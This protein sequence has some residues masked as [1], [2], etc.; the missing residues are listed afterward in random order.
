MSL[1]RVNLHQSSGGGNSPSLENGH[2]G[3]RPSVRKFMAILSAMAVVVAG[4]TVGVAGPAQAAV[5]AST[6][7]TLQAANNQ[8]LVT[9]SGLKATLPSL[10][11]ETFTVT[12]TDKT[13]LEAGVVTRLSATEFVVKFVAGGTGTNNKLFLKDAAFDTIPTVAPTVAVS[14]ISPSS[15]ASDSFNLSGKSTQ[16]E[17]TIPTGVFASDLASGTV[18]NKFTFTP[19]RIITGIVRNSDT[20]ATLTITA[21][22]AAANATLVANALALATAAGKPAVVATPADLLP[23]AVTSSVAAGDNTLTVTLAGTG[24]AFIDAPVISDF[25]F[26][27]G[28]TQ[29]R[30]ALSEGTVIATVPADKNV[31]VIRFV[32]SV[33]N[34]ATAGSYTVLV[35]ASALKVS[36]STATAAATS[37]NGPISNAFAMNANTKTVTVTITGGKFAA[38]LPTTPASSFTIA[39]ASNDALTNSTL[40]RVNDTTVTLTTTRAVVAGV[41]NRLTPLAAALVTIPTATVVS[42][43]ASNLPVIA[44]VSLDITTN[45]LLITLTG[46]VYVANPSI[47]D[48]TFDGGTT[49]GRA[50]LNAGT[51]TRVSDTLVS[52]RFAAAAANNA[53]S[54]TVLVLSSAMRTSASAG[55]AVG[56]IVV[57]AGAGAGVN[58]LATNSF[59]TVK[60]TSGVFASNLS[61]GTLASKFTIVSTGAAGIATAAVLNQGTIVRSSDTTATLTFVA[62]AAN[63]GVT[64]YTITPLAAALASGT[65]ATTSL[66]VPTALTGATFGTTAGNN[67]V[68]VTLTG[69]TFAAQSALN[70]TSVV[71]TGTGVAAIGAGSYTRTSDTVLTISGISGLTTTTGTANTITVGVAALASREDGATASVV[72]STVVTPTPTPAPAPAPAPEPAAPVAPVTPAPVV[73]VAPV[74]PA[75]VVPVTPIAPSPVQLVQGLT[76][77]QVQGLS[78]NQL[79]ALPP[80]A[81]AAMSPAQVKA[82]SPAQVSGF[83]PAQIQ[84]IPA[85]SL[86]AMKPVTLAKFSVTQLRALTAAQA[87]ELRVKQINELGPVKRKIVNNKR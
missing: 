7:T 67:T 42:V 37:V 64:A 45:A 15:A 68:L 58:L 34:V 12:G 72:A 53:S 87:S 85:D 3:R 57:D 43:T 21:S 78:A 11:S 62:T 55:T 18:D 47:S 70:S 23:G 60:L 8:L 24:A 16:V 35:K 49:A 76:P 73:P 36:A 63:D 22:A 30:A 50:A 27:G 48:F 5:P 77:T 14:T 52:V 17:V 82:L 20:K 80:A 6:D 86:R 28:T 32:A 1:Q 59:V 41:D 79:A 84:A 65:V 13:I 40:T 83:S 75:P 33:A 2:G 38:T 26:D 10:A 51:I 74:T 61:S 9:T 19:A 31:A 56:Q 71:P 54:Y 29:G 46:G 66:V 25:V 44:E 4:L 81:F 69:A 39:G